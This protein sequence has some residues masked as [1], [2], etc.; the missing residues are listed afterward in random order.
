MEFFLR[1]HRLFDTFWLIGRFFLIFALM[2]YQGNA[3][4]YF[5][6]LS[7]TYS[8]VGSREYNLSHTTRMRTQQ[9]AGACK[10]LKL[11]SRSLQHLPFQHIYTV[12]GGEG[13]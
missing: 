8:D 10:L 12:S 9:E 3:Q 13:L 5:W 6:V 7:P 11:I 4:F 2:K 1:L